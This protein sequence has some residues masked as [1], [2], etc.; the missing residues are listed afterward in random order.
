VSGISTNPGGPILGRWEQP[1]E[2]ALGGLAALALAFITLLTCIDVAGRYVM[3]SPVPGAL[4]V[5]ELVMGALIFTSLPLVT[6]RNQ[7]VTVDLFDPLIPRAVKPLLHWLIHLI[8][9]ACLAVIA[10]R[11]WIKAGQMLSGGDTT[12]VLQVHIWPLVYYMSFQA[13]V[14]TIVL[15]LVMIRG[16]RAESK[17]E[18]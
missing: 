13:A 9:I 16:G 7:Q 5:T 6:L 12:A 1:F 11:L 15:F 2:L 8:A 10:W 17:A 18:S 4:E 3:S 14:T